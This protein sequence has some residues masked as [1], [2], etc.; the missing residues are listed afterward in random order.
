M[1]QNYVGSNNVNLLIP[2]G[3]FGTRLKGGDDSASE[4]YIFTALNK[5]TRCIFP[6]LDDNVLTY[7]KDDGT[8]V[9]P[10]FYAPIIPMVLVNGSKGI[11]TGFSTDI[12]CYNPIEIIDCLKMKLN[13]TYIETEFVPYYEGFIG[14]IQKMTDQKYLI[15]GK[16]EKIDADKIRVVELPVGFWTDDFKELL[17]NLIDPGLDKT[18]KKI[19]NVVKDYQDMS[20][21]T[22]VEFTITFVKGQLDVMEASVDEN[23]C[24]GTEKLLKLYTT[25]TNTNMHLFDANDK[26]KKYKTVIEIIDDYFVTRLELYAKRKD[27]MI[28]ALENELLLLKNK[29]K[30]IQE[31]LDG[32]I[33]L[34]KKTKECVSNLLKDKNYEV[35]DGDADYKYLT[36][37]TMDSVT[38][39]NVNRLFLEH[40]NKIVELNIVKNTTTHEMWLNELEKLRAEY[41]KYKEDRQRPD[42]KILKKKIVAKTKTKL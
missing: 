12:M 37:M 31:N 11:G 1:A 13:D 6:V 30:Y 42:T 21:D 19:V 34:R 10:I 39:E 8:S 14:S 27:Y 40:E 41:L 9:E 26:L 35:I 28:K 17:E 23:G 18:G 29:A 7:L 2:S 25:N 33:D 3:Q 4:R 22:T 38:K 24:N 32:T 36:K 20:K 15:K 5:I 16:Y